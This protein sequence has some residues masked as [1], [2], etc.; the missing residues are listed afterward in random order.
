MVFQV[1]RDR[2][3][4]DVQVPVHHAESQ[5]RSHRHLGGCIPAGVPG[6]R[7]HGEYTCTPKRR[8][9]FIVLTI[10]IVYNSTPGLSGVASFFFHDE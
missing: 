5:D 3:S 4:H 1:L 9:A 10:L 2:S 6:F 8:M 7:C